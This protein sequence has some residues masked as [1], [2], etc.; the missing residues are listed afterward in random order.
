MLGP[1]KSRV[2]FDEPTAAIL[3]AFADTLI[4]PGEGFPAPSEARI[5]EDFMERYVASGDEPVLYAPGVTLA[6]VAALA[7]ALGD[8]FATAAE[9]ER[10]A[11]VSALESGEAELFAR[12]QS[13]VYAGYYSRPRVR[14]AI[15][16]NLEAG[17]DFRG[18]PQPY[19]YD[20]VIEQWDESRLPK[21]GSYVKT[22]EVTRVDEDALRALVGSW[23]ANGG[24]EA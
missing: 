11:A 7:A 19:G 17:R 9:D 12:L 21:R 8:G 3:A 5:V 4:P 20:D 23:P 10:V 1:T 14:A 24:D 6:D 16:A 13:L 15:A 18:A 2:T 22:D